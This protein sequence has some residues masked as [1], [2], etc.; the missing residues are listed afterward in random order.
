M[1]TS[2]NFCKCK[3]SAQEAVTTR[4]HE[5]KNPPYTRGMCTYILEAFG[6][7]LYDTCNL[8]HPGCQKKKKTAPSDEEKNARAQSAQV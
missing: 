6:V 5:S 3:H 7:F 2:V 1:L 4:L 8:L